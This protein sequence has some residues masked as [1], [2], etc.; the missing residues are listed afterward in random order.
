M[1]LFSS[2]EGHLGRPFVRAEMIRN[3]DPDKLYCDSTV[4]SSLPKDEQPTARKSLRQKRR[5]FPGPDGSLFL[6][7]KGRVDAWYGRTY[8]AYILDEETP[9]KPDVATEISTLVVS[10]LAAI[11]DTETRNAAANRV[12]QAIKEMTG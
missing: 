7:G 10:R 5:V 11:E 12:I 9:E 2:Q 6:K 1:S 3:L 8:K 4:T